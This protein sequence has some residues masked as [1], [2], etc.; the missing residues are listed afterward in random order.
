MAGIPLNMYEHIDKR[1]LKKPPNPNIA[2][3][4]FEIP[5]RMLICAASGSGKTSLVIDLLIRFCKGAGTFSKIQYICRDKS[6]PLLQWLESKTSQIE[7]SEGLKSLPELSE[8]N[9]PADTS[10]LIILDDMCLAKD[11]SAIESYYIRCRKRGVSIIYIS[12]SF[13]KVSKL[14]RSNCNYMI[15]LK[16]SGNRDVKLILSEFGLGIDRADLL[17]IYEYATETRMCPLVVHLD[18]PEKNKKFRRGFLE[19]IPV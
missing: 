5:F 2:D 9:F 18:E 10:S 12:Q 4:G 14:I 17:R 3:H 15:L 19:C 13:Y 1:F 7:V 6:E 8:K 11:Q 16:L